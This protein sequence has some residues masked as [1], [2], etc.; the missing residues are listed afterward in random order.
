MKCRTSSLDLRKIQDIPH[1][2]RQLLPKDTLDPRLKANI[3]NNKLALKSLS[4]NSANVN[5]MSE[6]KHYLH[7]YRI[8]FLLM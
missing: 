1:M 4:F 8:P 3:M 2:D 6:C 5:V 7:L